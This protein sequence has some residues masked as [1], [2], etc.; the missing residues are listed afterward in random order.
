M[1]T[2]KLKLYF[3]HPINTYNT[4]DEEKI[5][6]LLE[7]NR[8]FSKY[9]IENPNQPCHQE[10][11][12]QLTLA[13]QN[14]MQYFF[15]LV[16]KCDG[17]V[18]LPFANGSIGAGIAGEAEQAFKEGKPVFIIDLQTLMVEQVSNLDNLKVLSIEETRARLRDT[19]GN[20]KTEYYKTLKFVK[21]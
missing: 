8:I 1:E 10:G 14:G 12:K 13:G 2:Q 16:S 9:Q 19:E 11:Y 15:N 18:M 20:I 17:V 7:S 21:I 3:A 6:H 4:E 5:L